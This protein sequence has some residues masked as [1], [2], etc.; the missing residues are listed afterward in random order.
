MTLA[1]EID[2][3]NENNQG[4]NWQS[5]LQEIESSK[6]EI[7][8]YETEISAYQKGR[9]WERERERESERSVGR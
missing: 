4:S 9:D 5:E 1:V 8:L 7:D 3:I 2:Q 6:R